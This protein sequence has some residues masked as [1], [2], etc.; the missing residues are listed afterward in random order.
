MDMHSGC[1][2]GF[3]VESALDGRISSCDRILPLT[4]NHD[5]DSTVISDPTHYP[6]GKALCEAR[7]AISVSDPPAGQQH[8]PQ[9]YTLVVQFLHIVAQRQTELKQ[10]PVSSTTSQE[11]M[12]L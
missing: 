5:K 12:H 10:E 7:T 2:R 6:T 11:R 1:L 8:R 9:L 3:D 4:P